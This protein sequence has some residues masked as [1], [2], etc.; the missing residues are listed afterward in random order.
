MTFMSGYG[1]ARLLE[2]AQ[3][4][5]LLSVLHRHPSTLS[6]LSDTALKGVRRPSARP[7]DPQTD[8]QRFST[9][10]YRPTI[11][12]RETKDLQLRH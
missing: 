7:L 1:I 9:P 8:E 5:H 2:K 10:H 12:K 3:L 6:F 4:W 11:G